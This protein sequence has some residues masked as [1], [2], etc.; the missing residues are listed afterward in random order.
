[1]KSFSRLAIIL[2]AIGLCFISTYFGNIDYFT[3]IPAVGMDYGEFVI[4]SI[5]NS[6]MMILLIPFVLRLKIKKTFLNKNNVFIA[7]LF[8]AVLTCSNLA[9][10][11][12][13]L[14]QWTTCEI[15][16]LPSFLLTFFLDWHLMVYTSIFIFVLYCQHVTSTRDRQ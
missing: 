3:P 15:G 14:C 5:F 16:F 4:S 1:M 8:H 10:Q 6:L 12:E 7:T 11:D 13:V 2:A 9:L